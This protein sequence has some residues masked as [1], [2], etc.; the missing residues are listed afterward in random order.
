[1]TLLRD[2]AQSLTDELREEPGFSMSA[3]ETA[4]EAAASAGD[5]RA[6]ADFLVLVP[7]DVTIRSTLHPEWVL[8]SALLMAARYETGHFSGL[9]SIRANRDEYFEG[10]M[11]RISTL[12]RMTGVTA[13]MQGKWIPAWPESTDTPLQTA[14]RDTFHALFHREM[15]QE[16]EHGTVEVS[17]IAKAIPDMDIVGFAPKSRGAHTPQ[18]HLYLDTMEPFWKHLT[19]LLA[20]LCEG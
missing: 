5:T 3:A 20:S 12:C 16:V 8:S 18:E 10:T 11:L 14:C 1:M 17:V 2:M 6:L 13:A 19:A 9:L 15:Q 4:C 7:Y